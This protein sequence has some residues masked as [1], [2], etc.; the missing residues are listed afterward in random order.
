MR[1]VTENYDNEKVFETQHKYY[2][3]VI[4]D[5]VIE[6]ISRKHGNFREA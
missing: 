2:A 5:K 1:K 4:V 6:F 3:S